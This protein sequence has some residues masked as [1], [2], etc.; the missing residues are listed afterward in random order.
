[1]STGESSQFDLIQKHLLC[2]HI[3]QIHDIIYNIH[4]V[5]INL[6]DDYF[7]CF[8][9]CILLHGADAQECVNRYKDEQCRVNLVT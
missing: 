6:N 8:S 1:M 4:V 2:C 5:S 9:A 7:N 3:K